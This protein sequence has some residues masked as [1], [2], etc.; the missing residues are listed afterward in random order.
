[1]RTSAHRRV[2]LG[3]Q[4]TTMLAACVVAAA[5]ITPVATTSASASTQ[6]DAS[7]SSGASP[8][9]APVVA[10]AATPSGRGYWRAARDGGVLTA[11]DAPYMGS[12]N[13]YWHDAIVGMAT[14]PS[15]NGYWLVDRRGAVFSFGNAPFR[16]SMGGHVLN[17]P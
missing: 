12:A 4:T 7:V 16:G 2:R 8:R 5:L 17:K 3:T 11:G 1:M 14:T 9:V 6:T 13:R 15:G 10:V